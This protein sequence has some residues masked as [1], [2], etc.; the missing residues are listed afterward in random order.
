MCTD[1]FAFDTHVILQLIIVCSEKLSNEIL[2]VQ[3]LPCMD[4]LIS[5]WGAWFH[6]DVLYIAKKATAKSAK[7]KEKKQIPYQP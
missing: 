7:E 2:H 3:F 4:P 1:I 5:F 6:S